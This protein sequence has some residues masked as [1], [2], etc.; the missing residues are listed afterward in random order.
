MTDDEFF[1]RFFDR[2]LAPALFDHQGHVR[3]G[4][5]C[6]QRYPAP[7]AIEA[8]CNGIARYATHLGA[9]DKFHRTVTE[10]LMRMLV[11]CGAA[12]RSQ[13]WD[14]FVQ[15]SAPVLADARAQL[16]RHYSAQLLASD[17]ARRAFVAPDLLPL[18]C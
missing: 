14:A 3:L 13:G 2:S 18:P 12:D 1:D 10:A 8:A 17:A 15:R 4:W 7:L 9:A 6:L 5:I 11:Q 16:A